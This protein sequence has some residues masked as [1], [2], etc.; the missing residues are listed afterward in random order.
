MIDLVPLPTFEA[1]PFQLPALATD[2]RPILY[3]VF[4][5]VDSPSDHPTSIASGKE[6]L[7][8]FHY[9]GTPSMRELQ[10]QSGC[11]A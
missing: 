7:P 10:N 3:G 9:A 6:S 1:N 5:T 8:T 2:A 11:S 4:G